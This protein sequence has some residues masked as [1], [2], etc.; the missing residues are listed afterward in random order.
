MTEGQASAG[1]ESRDSFFGALMGALPE[2]AVVTDDE[3][4]IVYVNDAFTTMTGYTLDEVRGRNCRFLQGPGTDQATVRAVRDALRAGEPFRGRLL[5]HRKDGD[6]FWNELALAPIG[7][8]SGRPANFIALER[9]VS[10][11][12]ADRAGLAELLQ[13]TERER[14]TLGALLDTARTL[15][16][17]VSTEKV[18]RSV[19]DSI[20]GLCGSERSAVAVWDP[21]TSRLSIAA[22]TGWPSHLDELMTGAIVSPSTSPELADIVVRPEPVLIRDPAS[23]AWARSAL[24]QYEIDAFAAVPVHSTGELRGVLLAY[25]CGAGAPTEMEENLRLRLSGLAGIAAIALDNARLMEETH[26]IAAHDPLTGLPNRSILEKRLAR[27]LQRTDERSA[28]AVVFCD[29]DGLKQTNDALGHDAGDRVLM[30]VAARLRASLRPGDTV[31]RVGGDEFV[32]VLE[33]VS[34]EDEVQ[35]IIRR[36]EEALAVPLR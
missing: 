5:N 16:Q 21:E 10:T 20:P 6:A 2:A 23:S 29:I 30:E 13:Q 1:P 19:A 25:W 31:S 34:G 17:E 9:D 36:L 4:D 18:L 11:S 33:H 26:W 15:A 12:V 14:A 35:P 22:H 27:A 7:G 3:Q 32:I 28:T 8:T 24:E